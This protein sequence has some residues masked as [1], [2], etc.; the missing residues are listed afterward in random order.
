M[1]ENIL[2]HVVFLSQVL[3]ISFYVPR[4]ML[5]RLR[6]VV[7]TY[8]PSDYPKLYPVSIDTVEKGMGSFRVLNF[9]ILLVGFGLVFLG[10][11]PPSEE[12]LNWRGQSVFTIYFF[13]QTTPF[14]LAE[15]AGFKY[16]E[17]MRKANSR[18]TRKADLH[19]RSLFNFISPAFI[20]IAIFTYIAFILLVLYL[21]QNPYP[22]FGGYSN[23]FVVTGM[24]LVIAV[25]MIKTLYGKKR[26][27]YQANEDRLWQIELTVKFLVFISIA[28]TTF[29]AI[30]VILPALDSRNL[31]DMFMSLHFQSI[32]AAS[33]RALL[34]KSS[35]LDDINF[36]VYKKEP[37][38]T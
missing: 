18:S 33:F 11:Y 34:F 38:A 17:L 32:T 7:E 12:M 29:M 37:L 14:V 23:V 10:V 13:L 15:L 28:G 8:P 26:D 22:G 6:Y 36:E 1:P 9:I 21:R 31:T 4:K 24:N 27:P 2:L 35:R 30:T 20:G 3:F 16:F 19:P 5:S 25:I